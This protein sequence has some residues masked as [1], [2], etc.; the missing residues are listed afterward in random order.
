MENDVEPHYSVQQCTV[1]YCGLES[2]QNMKPSSGPKHAVSAFASLL[3]WETRTFLTH[4]CVVK[5]RKFS[6]E[7]SLKSVFFS[8]SVY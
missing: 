2:K 1:F 7:S 5:S 4:A 3:L 6:K 8:I